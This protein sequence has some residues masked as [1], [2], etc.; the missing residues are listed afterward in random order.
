[1]N[2][3]YEDYTPRNAYAK[4]VS[5]VD[6]TY[7]GI[8]WDQF[9][10]LDAKVKQ[11][12]KAKNNVLTN[13]GSFTAAQ[14]EFV[15]HSAT[16][17]TDMIKTVKNL[18]VQHGFSDEELQAY[19]DVYGKLPRYENDNY[20]PQCFGCE[21]YEKIKEKILD[22]SN[23]VPSEQK[24]D[25]SKIN[26]EMEIQKLQNKLDKLKKEFLNEDD[27]KKQKQIINSM[28]QI[29]DKLQALQDQTL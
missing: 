16:S 2:K 14:K 21:K 15:K 3:E 11:A 8:Y 9:D 27:T 22:E 6:S 29:V 12:N 4:F 28:N 19:F 26:H 20:T 13:G 1:M 5:R 24:T 18:N 23:S 7:H 25:V 17:R 10:Y